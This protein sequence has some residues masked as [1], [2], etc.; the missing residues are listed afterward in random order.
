M[1]KNDIIRNCENLQTSAESGKKVLNMILNIL[2]ALYF[3]C[4]KF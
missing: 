2:L 1:D 4:Q 3:E